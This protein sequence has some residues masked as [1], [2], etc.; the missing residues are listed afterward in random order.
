M[1]HLF[2]GIMI[3]SFYSTVRDSIMT[4]FTCCIIGRSQLAMDCSKLLV[5]KGIAIKHIFT[6]DLTFRD[7]SE[8]L[9]IHVDEIDNLLPLFEPSK[10]SFFDQF[11][12]L[13]SIVN[14][15][16][17]PLSVLKA[18]RKF[19]INYHNGPLTKYRGTNVTHWALINGETTHGVVWH[20]I[21]EKVDSGNVFVGKD[22]T[23]EIDED[24][25][26]VNWKCSEAA[27][28]SF[29]ELC[30]KILTFS[31]TG[32]N[33]TG[34]NPLQ[35]VGKLYKMNE[36]PS[37]FCL[38]PFSRPAQQVYNFFRGTSDLMSSSMSSK[39]THSLSTQPNELGLPKV[40]F[41]SLGK[42]FVVTGMNI[43]KEA[44]MPHSVPGTLVSI[45]DHLRVSTEDY[46][47]MITGL[48]ELDGSDVP[49]PFK[50]TLPLKVGAMVEIEQAHSPGSLLWKLSEYAL[51]G[52]HE[53]KWVASFVYPGLYAPGVKS[54]H[55]PVL[56]WPYQPQNVVASAD[57]I[58]NTVSKQFLC[59]VGM[60]M[61]SS[62]ALHYEPEILLLA[63]FLCYLILLTPSMSGGFDVKLRG[64]P[65]EPIYMQ[66]IISCLPTAFC[67]NRND[68]QPYT[69]LKAIKE[70]STLLYSIINGE[71]KSNVRTKTVA[72]DIFI[73]Y[74]VK[75]VYNQIVVS[76]IDDGKDFDMPYNNKVAILCCREVEAV[77]I[78]LAIHSS[79]QA[80]TIKEDFLAFLHDALHCPDEQPI[81]CF[82]LC[83][84]NTTNF[85]AHHKTLK[86]P[87]CTDF[88]RWFHKP[89]EVIAQEL[90]FG[91]AVVDEVGQ[92]TYRELDRKAE[93]IASVILSRAQ[94]K[95]ITN[96]ALLL[97]RTW[98]S[99]AASLAAMKLGI[100]FIPIEPDSPSGFISAILEDSKTYLLIVDDECKTFGIK[101]VQKLE[102]ISLKF[103]PNA[104]K[105]LQQQHLE[106]PENAAV[107]LYTSGTTGKPKGILIE[108]QGL[109]N[110]ISCV[111]SRMQ[112]KKHRVEDEHVDYSVYDA[113]PTFDTCFLQLFPILWNGGTVFI[114]PTNPLMKNR[115]SKFFKHVTFLSTTPRKLSLYSSDVFECAINVAVGGEDP[116]I[117]L[118]KR[119][120]KPDRKL[121]NMYGPAEISV[122]TTMGSIQDQVHL[123]QAVDNSILKICNA[124]QVPVPVGVP[125]ELYVFG[126]GVA[127]GY[128]SDIATEGLFGKDPETNMRWYR[129]GDLVLLN[130]NGLLRYIG[131]I[132]LDS[133]VKIGGMRVELL[134]IEYAIKQFPCVEY[135]KMS[136]EKPAKNVTLLVA[137]IAPETIDTLQIGIRL[138]NLF[139]EHMLPSYIIPIK[140]SDAKLTRTGKIEL[141][142][143]K[144]IN[145][146][147]PCSVPPQ[148][149]LE[150]DLLSVY[151]ECLGIT[152]HSTMGM[153]DSVKMYG[154]DSVIAVSISDEI[155]RKLMWNV[156]PL[157]ILKYTP[158][159]IIKKYS[160]VANPV[161]IY[162]TK[163]HCSID[164]NSTLGPLFTHE[165]NS[166]KLVSQHKHS[167]NQS[168]LQHG[169]KGIFEFSSMQQS[170]LLL[171]TVQAGPAYNIPLV[172]E[173]SGSIKLQRF[174]FSVQKALHFF[175]SPVQLSFPTASVIHEVDL[176]NL[177]CGARTS[178]LHMIQRDACTPIDLKTLPFRCTIYY[179]YQH[180]IFS[181]IVHHMYFDYH[182]WSILQLVIQELYSSDSTES[183]TYQDSMQNYIKSEKSEYAANKRKIDEFWY[184]C[185]HGFPCFIPFPTSFHRTSIKY[186]RGKRQVNSFNRGLYR[187]CHNFCSTFG[188]HPMTL[189][190]SIFALMIQQLSG[191]DRFC[192]AVVCSRRTTP[193]LKRVV[194]FVAS[195]LVCSFSSGTL[196][197]SFS[198]LLQ[199]TES[200]YEEAVRNGCIPFEK[201]LNIWGYNTSQSNHH[202]PQFIL[203]FISDFHTPTILLGDGIIVDPINIDTFTAKAELLLDV[204]FSEDDFSNA[205]EYDS[206]LFTKEA[207]DMCVGKLYIELLNYFL[208][209]YYSK[210]C[211]FQQSTSSCISE[212]LRINVSNFL[213]SNKFQ[214]S[215]ELAYSLSKHQQ[216][217]V[218]AIKSMPDAYWGYFNGTCS[219]KVKLGI[220][221]TDVEIAIDS[222]VKAN[223]Y[224][225]SVLSINHDSL[226]YKQFSFDIGFDTVLDNSEA[227]K[228]RCREYMWPFDIFKG[229]LFHCTLVHHISD[230][231]K[232][233][234]IAS[235]QILL[236]EEA[237]RLFC[238][239]VCDTLELSVIKSFPTFISIPAMDDR[240]AEDYF[241]QTLNTTLPLLTP[242]PTA[243]PSL[244]SPSMVTEKFLDV[245][246]VVPQG[247]V[248]AFCCVVSALM[249]WI[250]K[251]STQ[252]QLCFL[253]SRHEANQCFCAC[254][255]ITPLSITLKDNISFHDLMQECV[256]T[257]TER[258]SVRLNYW[259]VQTRFDPYS[260]YLKPHHEM[261]VQ[262]VSCGRPCVLNYTRPFRL[263]LCFKT[264][265][266]MVMLTSA[267][268]A[269]QSPIVH[270]VFQKL[271][272]AIQAIESLS[273]P[274]HTLLQSVTF[275]PSLVHGNQFNLTN[276]CIQQMIIQAIAMKA[277]T[278]YC[279]SYADTSKAT[280]MNAMTYR[281]LGHQSN[282]LATTLS[283]IIDKYKQCSRHIALLM[284]GEFELPVAVIAAVLAHL[285]FIILDPAEQKSAI[286]EKMKIVNPA[287]MLYD[288]AHLELAK[289]LLY[290]TFTVI[291]VLVDVFGEH[292]CSYIREEIVSLQVPIVSP[293]LPDEV[294]Y[295]VFTSGSTGQ[296][297]AAPI[298]VVS[299]CNFLEWHKSMIPYNGPLNWLQCSSL[300]F[301][302][303]IAEFL[304]Q[305]FC[306]NTLFLSNNNRKMD[307]EN[308]FLKILKLFNIEGMHVVPTFLSYMLRTMS[309]S[310]I[311]LNSLRHVFSTGEKLSRDVCTQFFRLFENAL[312]HNWG[313]ASECTIE[314]MH[315]VL[316][317]EQCISDVPVGT[318]VPNS[319][320]AVVNPSSLACVPKLI[321]GEILVTGTVVFN[322]Y[323]NY[324]TEKVLIQ[325]D[326]KTWYRTEDIGYI[327]SKN[328]IVLL[329]RIGS[330]RKV[331][332]QS[333]D[334]Q[335]VKCLINQLN[336]SE[337]QDIIVDI[338]EELNPGLPSLICFP[339]VSSLAKGLE[340]TIQATLVEKLPKRCVPRVIKCLEEHNV[341]LLSSGKVNYKV[342]RE[343][344]VETKG[345]IGSESS[346]VSSQFS[347]ILL[348]QLAGFIPHLKPRDLPMRF[349][350]L[351]HLGLTSMHIVSLV[352][353]LRECGLRIHVSMLLMPYTL[354]EII[355]IIEKCN[356][357]QPPFQCLPKSQAIPVYSEVP[358]AILTVQVNLPGA[359]SCNEFWDVIH[360]CVDTITHN[361]P[362]SESVLA[363]DEQAQYVGSRGLIKDRDAF[364][365]ELFG[366][367]KAH[368]EM[369][370][371]QQRILIQMVWTALEEIGCAPTR[372]TEGQRI[373]CFAGVQFP[374]YL[375]N[376]L[377]AARSMREQDAAVWNNCRDNVSLL[378]GQILD[379]RG[380]CVTVANN[381]ATFAV[382]LH[383]A[384]CSLMLGE[385]DIAVVAAGTIASDETGY[386]SQKNDIYSCDGQCRPF[387]ETATGTVMSD[388]LVVI[389]LKRLPDAER[390]H[391][392]I[393]CLIRGSAV[394]ADG[395]L[396][397]V[398][399]YVPSANGQIETLRRVFH[400]SGVEPS[401]ISLVEAHGTGTKVGDHIELESLT[402][403]FSN[404]FSLNKKCIL[405][406]VKG[407]IGH[408][409]VASAGPSV[410]KA[411]LAL[412]HAV[413]P[414][415]IHCNNPVPQLMESQIFEVIS[416]P[417]PWRSTP[418]H[419]RMALVHSIGAL[420]TNCAVIL[421]EYIGRPVSPCATCHFEEPCYPVCISATSE[422]SLEQLCSKI[423]KYL[424]EMEF[425]N[426]LFMLRDISYT[427]AVGRKNLSIRTATVIDS[428]SE[429]DKWL[430]FAPQEK[431]SCVINPVV[432]VFS[433]FG[434]CLDFSSIK[435]YY[436]ICPSLKDDVLTCFHI[437]QTAFPENDAEI[438]TLK[439]G[440]AYLIEPSN[441]PLQHVLNV[442]YQVAMYNSLKLLG[443]KVS[444]IMGH[445][446]GEYAAAYA[447]G[448]LSLEDVLKIVFKRALLV[449]KV[450]HD[451]KMLRVNQGGKKLQAN[452][453]KYLNPS[454]DVAVA[455]FNSPEH[456]VVSGSSDDLHKLQHLLVSD[457]IKCEWLNNK[458]AFHHSNLKQ[459]EHEFRN[460][461]QNVTA[462][463]LGTTWLT[464]ID[465]LCRVNPPGTI[466]A[467]DYW[468]KHLTSAVN[469]SEACNYLSEHLNKKMDSACSPI[470]IEVGMQS[471][472]KI[473]LLSNKVQFH[474]VFSFSLKMSHAHLLSHLTNIWKYGIDIEFNKM[475]LYFEANRLRLP[476]YPFHLQKYW[477]S[478][479]NQYCA[480][481]Q[482][483]VCNVDPLPISNIRTISSVLE[484]I[485]TLTGDHFQDSFPE[486]SAFLLM[487]MESLR[488]KYKANV[489]QLLIEKK[490]PLQIAEY[491]CS[492][493]PVAQVHIDC[494][495]LLT[496]KD[497]T[498]PKIFIMHAVGGKLYSFIPLATSMSANFQVYGVYASVTLLNYDSTEEYAAF[499]LSE[500]RKVQNRGPYYIGGFSFGAWLAHAVA[501][502]LV[503]EKE[504]VKLFMI[505]PIPLQ[506]VDYIVLK[507]HPEFVHSLVSYGDAFVIHA[508]Q[509]SSAP[510]MLLN[511]A[512]NFY[513]QYELLLQYKMS[514]TPVCCSTVILLAEKGISLQHDML[515]LNPEKWSNTVMLTDVQVVKIPGTHA[516][517]IASTYCCHIASTILK[518][519]GLCYK[520][521]AIPV[522][523]D[524]EIQ[525]IWKVHIIESNGIL[526]CFRPNQFKVVRNNYVF[527]LPD[528]VKTT[529]QMLLTLLNSSG[530]FEIQTGKCTFKIEMSFVNPDL[531]PCE[532]TGEIS[533][534]GCTTLRM[535]IDK[536]VFILMN[537]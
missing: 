354:A 221:K 456:C 223:P 375:L 230:G 470:I 346:E 482:N 317:Y 385:C 176:S 430:S 359:T 323:L 207:I 451:G 173:I 197:G 302:I 514:C 472:M 241:R 338:V 250:L 150:K 281:E 211:D 56:M 60:S 62:L 299:F 233:I 257:L 206:H 331:A 447:C 483:S 167:D 122:I 120:K 333:I 284:Q 158:S 324:P 441:E 14:D 363:V 370:D 326:G 404:H 349:M 327:N 410:A 153:S 382:A 351:S 394:G 133:Q 282:L 128:T 504:Q 174:V 188:V 263:H 426:S 249:L 517:C 82:R 309:L 85:L 271:V 389:V 415:S 522:C 234:L 126:C 169:Q 403:V 383:Y 240:E 125:G 429:F 86:G 396:A 195:T 341:P 316:S 113:S 527:I 106:F 502:I 185:V 534:M 3:L 520:E 166:I 267:L 151:Q 490:S 129:T 22:I 423:K 104:S 386:W 252:I 95:I 416:S 228:I 164:K 464:S 496:P 484:F 480:Q 477:V 118:Y 74:S 457:G 311:H 314:M 518:S 17:I 427:L 491:I 5:K 344:A 536:H 297:K 190:L 313:G 40:F 466:I 161:S 319:E 124:L 141:D 279:Y 503:T 6:D 66:S 312:L 187:R 29:A 146:F 530:S 442:I 67:L 376:C 208:A 203:N 216:V 245:S 193:E 343:I 499:Y 420:G 398:R 37:A 449:E 537:I 431:R 287:I 366:I 448:A 352:D 498:K 220:T 467:V 435:I 247:S 217:I 34:C 198:E 154:G 48:K 51:A 280:S 364:D 180:C 88:P 329:Y 454:H 320:I 432:I 31:L 186:Y 513:K 177:P 392:D 374:S 494:M 87:D 33:P 246:R 32:C 138:K 460:C 510:S 76:V 276:K 489:S 361:L 159:E 213:L 286:L 35:P 52:R 303:C 304:G 219:Q 235:N 10:A 90:P 192:I 367:P 443:V 71:M 13:F 65:D 270:E 384:R 89:F 433:G 428:L 262:V 68:S 117:E 335:G 199:Y 19:S 409:G 79:I 110:V 487:L 485:K 461:F 473:L 440:A 395:A 474:D 83:S 497:D 455:C 439:S 11:D 469:F 268:N 72:S 486:D 209:H 155:H 103:I 437:L 171:N 23:I 332:G 165:R 115:C 481:G 205:W 218:K 446:L 108:H 54:K 278:I 371:P 64:I 301:D 307:L 337:V 53:R 388:G 109:C 61:F 143:S 296:P 347:K 377:S 12:Y 293:S 178:A 353:K 339:I 505:D 468:L 156:S 183:S 214:D 272:R 342:L 28:L 356:S 400:T 39:Q 305:L 260:D 368:A 105:Q 274:I 445:S 261:L 202:F 471:V 236:D 365:A 459:I 92:Y 306:G 321:P 408:T 244:A 255:D 300:S 80:V 46:D 26:A 49:K 181:L 18:V 73:R 130:S 434:Q 231:S 201:L 254:E 102:I 264:D 119:W 4:N 393:L 390:E 288:L 533:T 248:P 414:P 47:V 315:C 444:C 291:P 417:K 438:N 345:H 452:L 535:S 397:G 340:Q 111:I 251:R 58:S 334:L 38:L 362:Q 265:T 508:L 97:N 407:N 488:R 212:L 500:I 273:T 328:Q 475:P 210:M 84:E 16:I 507:Q 493:N 269:E 492:M 294:A 121:W 142:L 107:L 42:L 196:S 137:Y 512:R 506:A 20:E 450:E 436:E 232:E 140:L 175:T 96:V 380:P 381:C 57:A 479:Q 418:H 243:L 114:A 372:L 98:L 50:Q 285:T 78:Y 30:D 222:V 495:H 55:V 45:A 145:R 131:R 325:K 318:L 425:P 132:P 258:E 215:H 24:L 422:W 162:S 463:K 277:D 136:V 182:S 465:G 238:G 369:L 358:I 348:D 148:S 191:V 36:K 424:S 256:N 387:S 373:G 43:L 149:G 59:S 405:G 204:W 421:E 239:L 172:F 77:S 93:D 225:S 100:T 160:H 453:Q 411:A 525:G 25:L 295:V 168:G 379:F 101:C 157:D 515:L 330:L 290:S 253:H 298:P 511:F 523:S 413:L 44:L 226:Q 478:S 259:M 116:S 227:E 308:Y 9:S 458:H 524:H 63:S 242:P 283:S 399:R 357:N 292:H 516:T 135:V 275:S 229:P 391:D 406:S 127:R 69:F 526:S 194:G 501:K 27:K 123:G 532:I 378:I 310:K 402:E 419:N 2:T 529:N 21:N 528:C 462:K 237:L 350:T 224:L 336:I 8:G 81:S 412:K 144:Y 355:N 7:W 75:P 152:H 170:L 200:W 519:S 112:I 147:S 179:S 91:I 15:I 476:T 99:I 360:N 41:G 1:L 134:G 322:R 139:P 163:Q 184:R 401:S 266:K 70:L 531:C 94:G 509:T 189:F 521:M 289:T